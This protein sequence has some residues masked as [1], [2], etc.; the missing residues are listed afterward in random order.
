LDFIAMAA[1]TTAPAGAAPA[2]KKPKNFGTKS[3]RSFKGAKQFNRETANI[4]QYKTGITKDNGALSL[5]YRGRR[6]NKDSPVGS[7]MPFK[8]A[9]RPRLRQLATNY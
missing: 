1:M 8:L 7:N 4:R 3:K 5:L 2:N 6:R 9:R